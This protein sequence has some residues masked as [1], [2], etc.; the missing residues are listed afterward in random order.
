M[1]LLA[2]FGFGGVAGVALPGGGSVFIPAPYAPI[3]LDDRRSADTGALIAYRRY[4]STLAGSNECKGMIAVAAAAS[5]DNLA[6]FVQAARAALT[7]HWAYANESEERWYGR[8]EKFAEVSVEGPNGS[9][10]VGP[11]KVHTVGWT[12]YDDPACLYAV[13]DRRGVMI[14][15]WILNRHGGER[16]ARPLAGRIAA[17]FRT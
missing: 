13:S 11:L 12:V 3:A 4:H 9:E 5:F 15:I 8:P 16:Q 14:A 7:T 17:S 1:G 10:R 6:L 2:R